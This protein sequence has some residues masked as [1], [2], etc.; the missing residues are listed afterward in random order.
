M[1]RVDL[2]DVGE[3]KGGHGAVAHGGVVAIEGVAHEVL[4]HVDIVRVIKR[5]AAV[6]LPAR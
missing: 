3:L 1:Q 4:G 2:F 5:D 6:I